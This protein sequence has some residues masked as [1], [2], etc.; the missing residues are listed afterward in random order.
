MKEKKN[1]RKVHTVAAIYNA[2][3]DHMEAKQCGACR[4]KHAG[5]RHMAKAEWRE[6]GRER[7][8]ACPFSMLRGLQQPI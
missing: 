2:I 8:Q 6:G 7:K 5:R 4:R 3:S 1:Y